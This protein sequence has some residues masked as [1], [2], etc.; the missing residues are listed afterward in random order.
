MYELNV[1]P[2]NVQA[3][4]SK[5]I[6]ADGFDLTFDM[7]K[8]RGVH[9]YDAKN[10]R[11]LLDF[12]TC[13]ASVPLGYNHPKMLNDEG[14]KKNLLLAALTNPSN[15]DIYTEQ[16]AQFVE[17][18]GRVGIPDYLPH[19][20][21]IA[22]GSLAI[23]NALKVA[24]DWKVQKNFAKGHT[25]EKGFKVIHFENAFHGRSGY[26]LSLT[27]T[28][29]VK[30]KWFAKFDWPRVSLPEVHFP[31][32]ADKLDDLLAREAASIAQIKQAFADNKDDICAIIIEPV[33]SEGGDKHVRQEFLEQLRTLADDNEAMLV[34][35]EVQTG[36]G[37]SGK[38]W[39]H[40]HFGE[41]ARPDILAFGKKMQVCGILAGKKVDEVE[42]NVFKVSS[43]INSTWGGSL[44]DMVRSSKIMEIIEEDGLCDKAAQTGQYLQNCLKDIAAKNS[45]VSNVRGKGLLTAF[46]FPDA[47]TRN[48]FIDIG[49]QNNIMYLGCGERSIR[50][51][52]AL[53]MEKEHI[54]EGMQ[55][56]QNILPKL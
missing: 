40:Q 27:N 13:F 52:P 21:F 42:N 47:H 33:L 43:R 3:A 55:M 14:F 1:N 5:H 29:P 41:K 56:L 9:I 17:T 51:R 18:F 16:Y 36:V 32:T 15:S 44:V 8:S 20:F 10:N 31:L 34:Y 50:F 2:Q 49:L 37:L 11:T 19:A 25:T 45:M 12:F 48:T 23:E 39:L 54:D 22:G 46:D 6:L 7:E 4:L 24:M 53:I 26:T 38:F 35:D 30:T 28:Q